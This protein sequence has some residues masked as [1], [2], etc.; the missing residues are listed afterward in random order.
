MKPI[1]ITLARGVLKDAP[2]GLF[3]LVDA[4]QYQAIWKTLEGKSG[5]LPWHSLLEHTGNE[6]AVKAGPL[7]IVIRPEQ[8]AA[9]SN[10]LQRGQGH[11]YLS[12][13]VSPLPHAALR[14]HLSGLLDIETDDGSTWVMRYFDTRIL[15]VW[16]AALTD[17]QR[18]HALGPISTWGY[19]NRAGKS[20]VIIGKKQDE[21]PIPAVLKL[22]QIQ[23]NALL[24]AAYPDAIIQQLKNNG[25]E[26][27]QAM[28][29]S[30]RYPFIAQQIGKAQKQYRIE[31]TPDVLLFCTLALAGGDGFEEQPV[32]AQALENSMK[33]KI[34]FS[35]A[36]LRHFGG[37]VS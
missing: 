4:A 30:A 32:L 25:N 5:Q 34:S 14:N 27:L 2:N 29:Q 21:V 15:P 24:D 19:F 17:A 33:E 10:F 1:D 7:L 11:H 23:E 20:S 35:D 22:T 16:H 28:P 12:W 8:D 13:I 37:Q 3:L 31:S 6:D 18:A 36:Y 9:L 26:D